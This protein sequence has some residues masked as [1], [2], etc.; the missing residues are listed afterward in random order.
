MDENLVSVVYRLLPVIV[1]LP[2]YISD[3]N[4]DARKSAEAEWWCVR[5]SYPRCQ[6]RAMFS[7]PSSVIELS[8]PSVTLHSVAGPNYH[9][10]TL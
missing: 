1:H 2:D 7:A 8:K 6:I 5:H 4:M 10:R 9:H 3:S